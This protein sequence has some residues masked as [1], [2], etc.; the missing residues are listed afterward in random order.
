MA[1]ESAPCRRT[2]SVSSRGPPALSF[3]AWRAL[4]SRLPRIW[5]SLCRSIVSAASGSYSRRTDTSA[6]V[7]EVDR[8]GAVEQLGEVDRFGDAAA[9]RIGLLRGDDVADVPDVRGDRRG[10]GLQ[11]LVLGGEVLAEL[12]QIGRHLLAAL[13]V[14]RG[15]VAS[16]LA[17][18]A[19]QRRD[20]LHVADAR[21]AQ[22]RLHERGGHAEAV[23]H[24]ADVVQ[25]ARGHFRHAGV[26][27][28]VAQL[29][30][31]IALAL[32]LQDLVGHVPGHAE[33][34]FGL[35]GG[36]AEDARVGFE[37]H[38]IA[39]RGHHA[40]TERAGLACSPPRRA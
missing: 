20:A 40:K 38:R 21:I 33:D 30:L 34:A 5:I 2:R 14:R 25:H 8:H 35:A 1:S 3:S 11:A 37:V 6:I 23:Q 28:G 31:Q 16:S 4:L 32:F 12:R 9:P 22:L 24:V 17:L 27:R 10:L 36:V 29:R 19:Q 13:V 15:N 18:L 39:E 26:A 7:G